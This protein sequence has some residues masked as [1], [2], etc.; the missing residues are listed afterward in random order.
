MAGGKIYRGVF[1]VR[2]LQRLQS[3]RG[4]GKHLV[5]N[6]WVIILTRAQGSES[7]EKEQWGFVQQ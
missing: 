2:M 7:Q 4:K 1:Q 6:H 5:L 3:E